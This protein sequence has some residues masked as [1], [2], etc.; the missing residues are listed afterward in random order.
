MPQLPASGHGEGRTYSSVH[1]EVVRAIASRQLD[2]AI[3]AIGYVDLL[4]NAL[5]LGFQPSPPIFLMDVRKN[6]EPVRPALHG[7]LSAL[8]SGAR[9]GRRSAL[10]LD[11]EL[12]QVAAAS[13]LLARQSDEVITLPEAQVI[14]G[15]GY[16]LAASYVYGGRLIGIPT[17][18]GW[19]VFRR[20]VEELRRQRQAS[21]TDGVHIA[22][23]AH[24]LGVNMREVRAMAKRGELHWVGRRNVAVDA[25]EVADVVERLCV[26]RLSAEEI[27]REARIPQSLVVDAIERGELTRFPSRVG[28]WFAVRAEADAY[29]AQWR[30]FFDT[31]VDVDDAAAI[32]GL[33]RAQLVHVAR[34]NGLSI[35]LGPDLARVGRGRAGRKNWLVRAE[36]EALALDRQLPA[37]LMTLAELQRRSGLT[38]A[39]ILHRIEV[40]HLPGEIDQRAGPRGIG[41]Y[42]VPREAAEWYIA[43]WNRRG[44]MIPLAKAARISRIGRRALAEAARSGELAAL[45]VRNGWRIDRMELRRFA[46]TRGIDVPAT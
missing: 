30:Q 18:R 46:R 28:T 16:S 3:R 22:L 15:C 29:I 34:R 27:A 4:V 44:E 8:T 20:E 40:G 43:A 14:L 35:V 1:A 37:E 23:V 12:G 45:R 7:A 32:V 36:V 26:K 25:R 39:Q 38:R 11:E 13:R 9:R 33:G 24:Q 6:L 21:G 19:R 31:H 41:S 5:E 2:L 42:V 10:I 17:E